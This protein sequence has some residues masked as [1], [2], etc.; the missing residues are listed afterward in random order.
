MDSSSA[1]SVTFR[2]LRP[3]IVQRYRVFAGKPGRRGGRPTR[4]PKSGDLEIGPRTS[5]SL[6]RLLARRPEA[7]MSM[8]KPEKDTAE[9]DAGALQKGRAAE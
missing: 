6:N 2:R 7:R 4:R 8:M 3:G 9:H 5:D 1:A